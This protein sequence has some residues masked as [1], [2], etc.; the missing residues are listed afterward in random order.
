MREGDIAFETEAGNDDTA[1]KPDEDAAP[2]AEMNQVI[3]SKRNLRRAQELE[4]IAA[5]LAHLDEDPD[6]IGCCD[7]CGDDIPT[8]RLELMPWVRL[9]ISCQETRE[10]DRA[11]TGGRKHITDYE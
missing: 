4:Q 3:A 10:R 8:R 11:P 6:D 9:C 5:A 1:R 7:D 2:L